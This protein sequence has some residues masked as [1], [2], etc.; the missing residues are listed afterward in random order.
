MS[1]PGSTVLDGRR[2][3][4]DPGQMTVDECIAEAERTLSRRLDFAHDL[5]DAC[6]IEPHRCPDCDREC[7][8]NH[9]GT[10]TCWGCGIQF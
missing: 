1:A 9:D 8:G 2:V 10:H 3:N 7:P 6:F 5:G 4:L